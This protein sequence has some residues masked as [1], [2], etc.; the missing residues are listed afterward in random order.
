M[1]ELED[2][3]CT[4][5]ESTILAARSSNTSWR[6]SYGQGNESTRNQGCASYPSG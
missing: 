2:E 3:A 6:K 5:N 1:A 4:P